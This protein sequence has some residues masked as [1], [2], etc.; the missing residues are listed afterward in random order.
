MNTILGKTLA[1]LEELVKGLGQPRF[2]GRQIA[3]WLYQKRVTSFDEM[4]NLPKEL[5]Q[6]LSESYTIGRTAPALTQTSSDR[7]EK[8]LFPLLANPE[9]QFETV[10]I[11]DGDRAT[12][13]VSSQ[14]GCKMNCSF[15]ATGK[16][17]WLANLT[18]ADIINQVLSMPYP[19]ELTNMVFMGMGE[20]LDNYSAVAQVIE[21]LTADYGFG[22][23]PK[24]ITV[25]TIGVKEGLKKLL[26]EQ[27]VHVAIS[28]H[29]AIPEERLAL[30][31]VEKAFPI[32][33]V[34]NTLK[35]YDFSGQRRLSFEYILFEGINDSKLHAERL[36]ALLRPLDCRVNLIRYHAIPGI[37]YHT[38]S[39]EKVQ[40]FE[41]QLNNR[42]LRTTTRRSRGEDI[43][44][45]CGMLSTEN[46]GEA[47][48][49]AKGGAPIETFL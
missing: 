16:M 6:K 7:T 18:S 9:L 27:S 32:S 8:Y 42:G 15:C 10:Y 48:Q 28:I 12:L 14:V 29:N 43:S 23:S 11:P 1:Q 3:E 25:S 20:P 30:M 19:D 4:T 33:T 44:A 24:R 36:I 41:D 2:R 39:A 47:S 5:R 17:G 13:C 35:G 49:P 40:W 38:P 45:A 22:W 46:E 21:I 34:I 37:P 26:A 31:P